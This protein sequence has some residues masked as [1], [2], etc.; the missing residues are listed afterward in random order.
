MTAQQGDT[1]DVVIIAGDTPQEVL[2][3]EVR[4]RSRLVIDG[5][6]AS[7][8]FLRAYFRAGRDAAAARRA[9]AEGDLPFLSLNGPYLTQFLEADGLRVRLISLFTAQRDELL[10]ALA[11]GPRAVVISTTFLPFA[12]QIDAIAGFVKQHCPATTVIAGGIQVWKAY[13]HLRLAKTGAIAP[14]IRAAVAEH[15]Y[16]MDDTRPSPV[17]LFIV[18]A[19]GE[20]TLARVLDTLRAGG[21]PRPLPNVAAFVDGRWR[22]GEIEEEPAS[23]VQVDWGRFLG[24]PTRTYVPVQAGLG[25]R[26]GCTFCDFCGLRPVR[27]RGAT[28]V[29][30]EIRTIPPGP[31]GLRRVYFTDDNL[32]GT[33][34]R[35]REVLGA[36]IA[37]GLRVRWRGLARV[38]IV[39]RAVAE[40]MAESGCLEV[41]LGIESGDPELLR[42]M[43]KRTTPERILGGLEHLTRAG[44]HTKSTFMVGFPGETD[45]SIGRTVD[46]LNAYPV[47][48]NV[49]H[50]YLF[51]TFAV[52]P[53]SQVASPEARREYHLDGYGFHW[54]HD[55][56]DAATAARQMDGLPERLREDL[57]PSYVLE[58]P[59][60]EGVSA[61][62]LRRAVVV[63]NRLARLQRAP[64][65]P[66]AEAALWAELESTLVTGRGAFP[67]AIADW[68]RQVAP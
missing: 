39:D 2:G 46:L 36:L 16:L 11:A 54:R 35:A 53:L 12:K 61:A 6:Q 24:R 40:Q 5:A 32:F 21:D 22:L 8:P 26:F 4:D 45:A 67:P 55:T 64:G 3:K 51:F 49:L 50:R 33:R 65:D 14:D 58:I 44:I 29:V 25:C 17:D 47:G 13:Q 48:E 38:D 66:R 28:A 42:R 63:R 57:C 43:R 30:D 1:V 18:S 59:E 37:A 10:E 56:M 41:L 31:D 62:D 52:L 27:A 9:L 7:F 34:A 20:H 68:P 60:L 19:S 23:D 15:N